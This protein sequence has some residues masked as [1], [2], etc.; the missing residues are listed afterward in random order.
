MFTVTVMLPQDVTCQGSNTLTQEVASGSP[1]TLPSVDEIIFPDNLEF[2]RWRTDSDNSIVEG[3]IIVKEDTVIWMEVIVKKAKVTFI[4]PEGASVSSEYKTEY[5]IGIQKVIAPFYMKGSTKNEIVIPADKE[6]VQWNYKGEK[7]NNDTLMPADGIVLELILKDAEVP[8]VSES[9]ENAR[10][11]FDGDMKTTTDSTISVTAGKQGSGTLPELSGSYTYTDA[12]PLSFTARGLTLY[13]ERNWE[14]LWKGRCDENMSEEVILFTTNIYSSSAPFSIEFSKENGIYVRFGSSAKAI[15][16]S[17]EA[18]KAMYEMHEWKLSYDATEKQLELFMDSALQSVV[19][20]APTANF[21]IGRMFGEM[22]SAK[23]Y[24]MGTMEYVEVRIAAEVPDENFYTLTVFGGT[25][26][27][28][29]AAKKIEKGTLVRPRAEVPEDKSFYRW[30][31][32]DDPSETFTE[33]FVMPDRDLKIAPLFDGIYADVG[34]KGVSGSTGKVP[35]FPKNGLWRK[36]PAAF[37]E[38][39]AAA[40]G[41]IDDEL[42]SIFCLEKENGAKVVKNDYAM[43]QSKYAY[44]KSNTYSTTFTVKNFGTETISL[45]FYITGSGM[46]WESGVQTGNT[47]KAGE[48]LTLAPGAVGTISFE[49]SLNDNDNEMVIFQYVGDA[50]LGELYVGMY[51]YITG[52]TE[53]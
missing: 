46:A 51:Q 8:P 32:V 38:K 23:K 49:F 6:F 44:L 2:L 5:E 27:G 26:D 29:S 33:S 24:F 9:Y 40:I 13:Y 43:F 3:S 12:K 20:F 31:N 52:I 18:L 17:E 47:A 50:E 39:M 11:E 10:W 25:V 7:Y 45:Q 42:G 30:Y 41:T 4:L 22:Y 53:Y 14:V 28:Q 1:Y 21:T 15:F 48:V 19:A 16:N 34:S 37:V 35:I 36:T